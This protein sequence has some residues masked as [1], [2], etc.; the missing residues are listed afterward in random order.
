MP[1][2][3]SG[4]LAIASNTPLR[5]LIQAH[6]DCWLDVK[7][8]GTKDVAIPDLDVYITDVW[9]IKEKSIPMNHDVVMDRNYD[10]LLNGKTDYDEKAAVIVTH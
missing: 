1:N 2:D 3:I 5:E 4:M 8:K 10:L 7:G 9:S 6:K